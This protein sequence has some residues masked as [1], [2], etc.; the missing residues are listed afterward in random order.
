MLKGLFNRIFFNSGLFRSPRKAN[1]L[2]DE[3]IISTMSSISGS[4][5]QSKMMKEIAQEKLTIQIEIDA[6]VK[7]F[8]NG[9]YG[10]NLILAD[11]IADK[12]LHKYEELQIKV[13]E[14]NCVRQDIKALDSKT[15]QK[16]KEFSEEMQK[17]RKRSI[18]DLEK[19]HW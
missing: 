5:K 7:D 17:H 12:I 10:D 13:D 16:E 11:S 4:F 2:I 19:G 6:F 14:L 18:Y 3:G 8:E 1:D 9:K 15:K